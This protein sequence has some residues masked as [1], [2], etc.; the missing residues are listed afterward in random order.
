LQKFDIKNK[1]PD[2]KV[3]CFSNMESLDLEKQALDLGA[4]RYE[5][6][7]KFSPNQL[8][9]MVNDIIASRP[10]SVPETEL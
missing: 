4:L 10:K 9:T 2:A 3:I 6:K 1:H 8:A 5:V 7:A